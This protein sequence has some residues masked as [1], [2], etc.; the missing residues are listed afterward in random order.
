MQE[1]ILEYLLHWEQRGLGHGPTLHQHGL[2]DVQTHL[3]ISFFLTFYFLGDIPLY[4]LPL[5]LKWTRLW[6]WIPQPFGL[7]SS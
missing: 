7:G 5:L 4:L 3:F 1:G 2:K 6:T